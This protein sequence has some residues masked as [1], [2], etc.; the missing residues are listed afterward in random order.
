MKKKQFFF[1]M[2][3][4]VLKASSLLAQ[5]TASE[6]SPLMMMLGHGEMKANDGEGKDN[7][8]LNLHRNQEVEHNREATEEAGAIERVPMDIQFE[9]AIKQ[10]RATKTMASLRAVDVHE[11]S[12]LGS[13]FWSINTGWTAWYSETEG[14]LILNNGESPFYTFIPTFSGL[15]RTTIVPTIVPT[16]LKMYSPNNNS[17]IKVPYKKPTPEENQAV[18]K[19]IKEAFMAYYNYESVDLSTIDPESQESRT[20]TFCALLDTPENINRPLKM[21][22]IQGLIPKKDD[23]SQDSELGDTH[24]ELKIDQTITAFPSTDAIRTLVKSIPST[25]H[26][27]LSNIFEPDQPDPILEEKYHLAFEKINDTWQYPQKYLGKYLCNFADTINYRSRL[28]LQSFR[29]APVPTIISDITILPSIGYLAGTLILILKVALFHGARE[30][31]YYDN[32]GILVLPDHPISFHNIFHN[33][34]T[35]KKHYSAT[36]PPALCKDLPLNIT[37]THMSNMPSYVA[38]SRIEDDYRNLTDTYEKR[39]TEQVIDNPSSLPHEFQILYK[40]ASMLSLIKI[41]RVMELNRTQCDSI[42]KERANKEQCSYDFWYYFLPYSGA[43]AGTFLSVSMLEADATSKARKA[44]D[45]ILSFLDLATHRK[46]EAYH[47]LNG[48][49]ANSTLN[50]LTSIV[51]KDSAT[52]AA[53]NAFKRKIEDSGNE[54]VSEQDRIAL[55]RVIIIISDK[56][57]K[58]EGRTEDLNQLILQISDMINT[59]STWVKMIQKLK[60]N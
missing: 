18:R 22:D 50:T 48:E 23:S 7:E 1:L 24:P 33:T 15:P 2:L 32:Q 34:Y 21:R 60:F 30:H 55:A 35:I 41:T 45:P 46:S 3:I 58:I 49:F 14:V 16:G 27:E 26:D 38:P 12:E 20:A 42:L 43:V 52:V 39:N 31:D 9:N 17:E 47:L 19:L 10:E 6:A 37:T 13:S 28:L 25:Q 8:A 59:R 36:H 29:D 53:L 40:E 4:S 44:Q 57:R 5:N 54:I 56:I 51:D 11:V